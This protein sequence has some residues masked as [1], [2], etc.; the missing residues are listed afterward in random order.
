MTYQLGKTVVSGWVALDQSRIDGFAE[1]TEDRQFLHTDPGRAARTPFGGTIAHG[2]L[3]LSMLSS[4][5]MECLPAPPA[6]GMAVNY[7]FDRIRFPAPV[8]AG[9]RIRARFTLA[10]GQE[11]SP[12]QWHLVYD[13][14]V[15]VD[16]HPHPALVA[17]WLQRHIAPDSDPKATAKAV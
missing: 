11:V 1:V 5:A 4:L 8:P 3:T 17:R 12:G 15:E 2:F 9:A 7:G 16:A 13:V 14:T 10:E 6:G